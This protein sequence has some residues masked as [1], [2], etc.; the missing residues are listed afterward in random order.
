[1]SVNQFKQKKMHLNLFIN[2][3]LFFKVLHRFALKMDQYRCD[4]ICIT[5]NILLVTIIVGIIQK[6]WNN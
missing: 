1:M 3:Y 2:F 5:K 4:N 6:Q